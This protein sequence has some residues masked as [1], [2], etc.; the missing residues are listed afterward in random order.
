MGF[1]D[2]EREKAAKRREEFSLEDA[3]IHTDLVE[4]LKTTKPDIVFD[5]TVPEAHCEVV[6]TALRHGCHVL[7]EKPMAPTMAEA[8]RMVAAAKKADRLYAV[9]QSRRYM[10]PI[11]A[12]AKFAQSGRI[13][14]L[15]TLHAD[16]FIGAH[17]GG[18]RAE[19]EFPL[20]ADM[21]IHT[22]DSARFISGTD[23][24][25]V[26]CRGWNPKGSWYRGAASSVAIFEMTDGVVFTYRGSW[27]AEGMSTPWEADWRVIGEKGTAVWNGN[28][29]IRAQ[30][31][32]NAKGFRSEFREV[33]VPA[34]TSMD[35][36]F[37]G[38]API[39]V[40]FTKCLRSGKTPETICTDNIK[41]LAM[42]AAAV[43]S[44]R[45]GKREL[46]KV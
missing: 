29:A 23:P 12:L 10:P 27:C 38:H 19:M 35:R 37:T 26:Y 39:I 34:L 45:S 20:L 33:S 14:N 42:V 16:F 44:A 17:Y 41:T 8:R 6:L 30:I 18:F 31:V 15:T 9:T 22:F 40:E 32:K 2:L 11:Q 21:A 5:C 4:A 7:G 13:G 3:T 24:V 1:V 28:E 25:A 36:R 43:R 46:V